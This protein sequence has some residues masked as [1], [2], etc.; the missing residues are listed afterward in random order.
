MERRSKQIATQLA[1]KCQLKREI[2]KIAANCLNIIDKE[3]HAIVDDYKKS[4]GESTRM[5][6]KRLSENVLKI[7]ADEDSLI[8]SLHPNIFQ[9]DRDNEVWQTPYLAEDKE[10]GYVAIISIYNFISDSIDFNREEDPGY[11]VARIFINKDCSFYVE[12]KRQR[13]G[14]KHFGENKFDNA[15]ARRI[16]ETALKY[17]IEFDIL[18]PPYETTSIINLA[19]MTSQI[20]TS[21][22]RTGKRMGFKFNSDDVNE[23]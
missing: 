22:P 19:Y 18:V 12:G 20:I 17:A 2:G 23:N 13:L 15:I 10:R 3:M 1:A 9:F 5:E 4:I 7:V 21:K 16:I 6:T 8:V 14:V 11:M